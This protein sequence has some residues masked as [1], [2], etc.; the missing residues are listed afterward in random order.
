MT[1]SAENSV[2]IR[3]ITQDDM[4]ALWFHLTN[5]HGLS[6]TSLHGDPFS[7]HGA[8]TAFGLCSRVYVDVRVSPPDKT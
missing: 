5:D 8:A 7:M 2:P 6:V 3:V 1:H 4:N